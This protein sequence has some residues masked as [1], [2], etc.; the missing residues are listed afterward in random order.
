MVIVLIVAFGLFVSESETFSWFCNDDVRTCLVSTFRNKFLQ[1]NL[2]YK[3][4]GLRWFRPWRTNI[5]YRTSNIW[6]VGFNCSRRR[7]KLF[8]EKNLNQNNDYE[9]HNNYHCKCQCH[10]PQATGPPKKCTAAISAAAAEKP[11]TQKYETDQQH[12]AVSNP[13]RHG[14]TDNE[15][16]INND[17]DQH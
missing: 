9:C 4:I 10:Q 6:F 1:K 8:A 11:A 5:L 17:G 13:Y 12:R 16:M 14:L 15:D 2:P 7:S 3:E